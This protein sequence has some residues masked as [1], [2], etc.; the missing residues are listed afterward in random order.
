MHRPC[1]S[2]RPARLWRAGIWLT[3]AL[4]IL[5]FASAAWAQSN[6]QYVYDAL[7]R[8]T[9]IIDPSGN[10]ATYNYDAVGNL[11]SITRGTGSPSALAIFSFSP[12]QGSVGQ[13]VVIQGQNFSATPS[14]NTVQFNGTT[15]AVTAATA[16]QL[17]ATVPAG[18]ASGPISVTV[19]TSTA[20]S[21]SNFTVLAVPVITSVSPAQV[22]NSGAVSFTVNGSNLT[23]ATFSFLPAFTPA[24]ITVSNVNINGNGTSAAMTLTLAGNAVGSF[25]A[26]ATNANGSTPAVPSASNTLTIASADPLGDSDGDGLTNLYEAAIATNYAAASTT[27]DGL[28]DGWALFYTSAPPLNAGLTSQIAPNGLTYLQSFQQGLN[29]LLNTVGTGGPEVVVNGDG[30]FDS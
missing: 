6:V 3:T 26:V 13:T 23:G 27:G 4:T 14:A 10:I 12:A 20:T 1:L 29:P 15:A 28:P 11:L 24:A 2:G 21:S 30:S 17:T 25:T 8:L 22:L 5:G 9:Q 19:G 7:G 16:N 18:A